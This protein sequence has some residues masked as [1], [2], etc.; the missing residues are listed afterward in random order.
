MTL[1]RRWANSEWKN[2]YL[3][4]FKGINGKISNVLNGYIIGF[5][6]HGNINSSLKINTR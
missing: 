1:Y 4:I 2:E 3:I 6:T 5:K